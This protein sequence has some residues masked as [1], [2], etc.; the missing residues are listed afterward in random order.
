MGG[1]KR[2]DIGIIPFTDHV[3]DE[4]LVSRRL[5]AKEKRYGECTRSSVTTKAIQ[6]NALIFFFVSQRKTVQFLQSKIRGT[7]TKFRC[8]R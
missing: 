4:Q 3:L 7:V 6:G 8:R 1:M 5:L 2:L